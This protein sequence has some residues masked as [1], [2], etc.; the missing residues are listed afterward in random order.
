[1]IKLGSL[2]WPEDKIAAFFGWNKA[3]LHHEMEDSE[4][5]ISKLLLRG[6]L[7][8]E[9]KLESKLLADAQSGNLSSAR[10][11]QNIVRNRDFK[12]SKLDLFGGSEDKELFVKIQQYIDKGCPADLSTQEQLYLDALQMIYSLVIKFGNRK[13]IKLLSKPPYNLTYD[14]AKNLLSESIEMFAAGRRTSK[15]A[16]RQH[17]AE[18]Y[19]TLYHAILDSAKAPQDYALAASILDKKAKMLQLDQP[20]VE[21][22]Q[23]TEYARTYRVLSLTTETLGLPMA[24]RDELAAQIDALE[25]PDQDKR[26]L[27]MEASVVDMDIVKMLENVTQEEN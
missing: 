1:M 22:L 11:F 27:R 12:L 21:M 23:P 10:E 5:E 6:E 3:V 18:T 8:A 9:F 25:I 17:M 24:N 19:D 4:S 13:T 26:R 15:E 2:R 14:R 20:D 7:E 16:M